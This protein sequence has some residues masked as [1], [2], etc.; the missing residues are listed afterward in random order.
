MHGPLPQCGGEFDR[1]STVKHWSYDSRKL[2]SVLYQLL[3]PLAE[4]IVLIDVMSA[5]SKPTE[6]LSSSLTD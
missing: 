1:Q 4:P 2:K 3:E 6:D 5:I